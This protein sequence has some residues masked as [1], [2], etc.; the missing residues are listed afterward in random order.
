MHVHC[1]ILRAFRPHNILPMG[2]RG[3]CGI[4]TPF[5]SRLTFS[6]QNSYPQGSGPVSNTCWCII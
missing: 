3:G 6:A 4:T 1:Q 5:L 2:N